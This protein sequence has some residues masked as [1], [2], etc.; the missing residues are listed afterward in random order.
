MRAKRPFVFI[1]SAMTADGKIDTVE[2]KGARISSSADLVRVDLLR[3]E[4]DA[5]M[6]GGRT[7]LGEDPGLTVKSPLLRARRVERG[8]DENPIKVGIASRIE[9]IRE[10]SKFLGA[11]PARKVIFTSEQADPAAIARL[12]QLGAEVFVS[13]ERRVD[14]GEALRILSDLGVERLMVEGGGTLNAELLALGLVDE[15]V[16]YVAPLIFGGASAPTPADGPGLTSDRAIS[17]QLLRV[18]Q[19]E[20][21]GILVQYAVRREG[22][23]NEM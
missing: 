22:T 2:R 20:D 9:D 5:V 6:V 12:R 17:L 23:K 16:L 7:L 14:L 10:D 11:G 13:G 3:A 15:I 21:G 19:L 4:S 18:E 8:L 1:N